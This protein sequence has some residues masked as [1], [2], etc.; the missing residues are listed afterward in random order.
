M[1]RKKPVASSSSDDDAEPRPVI[2]MTMDESSVEPKEVSTTT[3]DE[4][5]QTPCTLQGVMAGFSGGTLGF[6]FGFGK[7]AHM[8]IRSLHPHPHPPLSPFSLTPSLPPFSNH[9]NTYTNSWIL[10]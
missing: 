4:G 7:L 6:L 10:A 1:G 9:Y 3:V 2:S 8:L 5:F